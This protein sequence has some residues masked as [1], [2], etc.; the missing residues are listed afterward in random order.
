MAT[1]YGNVI[2]HI[3]RQQ[4]CQDSFSLGLRVLESDIRYCCGV[5]DSTGMVRLVAWLIV[6]GQI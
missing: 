2:R 4:A 3:I 5:V 6:M 1:K